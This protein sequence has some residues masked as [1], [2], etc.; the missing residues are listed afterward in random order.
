MHARREGRIPQDE[1]NARMQAALKAR[2]ISELKHLES[3]L[4]EPGITHQEYAMA[5]ACCVL[6]IIAAWEPVFLSGY[7]WLVLALPVTV[8]LP[9][10]TWV[11]P[12]LLT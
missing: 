2:T 9:F 3:D 8:G 4:G 12:L 10:V 7:G 11:L 1:C 6:A 5:T